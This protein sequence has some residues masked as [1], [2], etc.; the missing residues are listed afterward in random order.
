MDA[1][2]LAKQVR[3]PAE[4]QSCAK[5]TGGNWMFTVIEDAGW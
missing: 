1:A 3:I 4:V 5:S 2:D